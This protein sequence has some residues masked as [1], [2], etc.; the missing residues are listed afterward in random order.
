MNHGQ[1]GA[2]A[3][4]IEGQLGSHAAFDVH[5]KFPVMTMRTAHVN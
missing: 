3:M 2:I 1:M 5:M 4:L